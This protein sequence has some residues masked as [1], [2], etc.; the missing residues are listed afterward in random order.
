MLGSPLY[1]RIIMDNLS[2]PMLMV[3]G[4]EKMYKFVDWDRY[5]LQTTKILDIVHNETLRASCTCCRYLPAGKR[6]L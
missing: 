5:I 1:S 2:G 6:S 4:Q 3:H